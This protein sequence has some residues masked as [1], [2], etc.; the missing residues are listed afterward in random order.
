MDADTEFK[1]TCWHSRRGML[2]LDLVLEPFVQQCYRLLPKQDQQRY[3]RLLEC[4]DTE[5][6]AWFLGRVRPEDEDLALIVDQILS[7]ARSRSA[8]GSAS[9]VA[10]E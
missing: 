6:F 2:E 8:P 3:Q 5:L 1:R 4:E 10:P 7:F 9:A